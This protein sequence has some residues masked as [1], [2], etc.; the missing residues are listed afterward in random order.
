MKD[1]SG[2]LAGENYDNDPENLIN[3]ISPP[4]VLWTGNVNNDWYTIG[5]WQVSSGP[6]RYP[7]ITDNVVIEKK[8]NQPIITTDGAVA[9]TVEVQANAILTLQSAAPTD[10]TLKV[11]EDFYN[12]GTVIMSTGADTLAVGGNWRNTG[13]FVAGTGT[14]I[15]NSVS[16]IKSIDNLYDPFYN[17]YI[18]TVSDI[19]LLRNLTINKHFV[20]LNGNFDLASDARILTVKGDFINYDNFIA[21][22]AKVTFAGISGTQSIYP[23]SAVFY[24]IDID[25]GSAANVQITDNNLFINHNLNINSGNFVLNGKNLYIGDGNGIDALTVNGGLFYV[26]AN[27]TLRMANLSTIEVNAG[28]TM[29]LVGTDVDNPAYLQSQTGTY[30]F[31]VNSGATLGARYYNIQHVN[32]NGV[33][34]KNGS[35]LHTTNNFSDGV[36]R[37]GTSGGQYLWFENNFASDTTKI[38]GVYFHSG[39]TYNAKRLSGTGVVAFLD[40]LGLLAGYQFEEDIPDNSLDDGFVVWQYQNSMYVWTGAVSNDWNIAANW[41]VPVAVDPSGHAVPNSLGIASIPDVSFAS[42]RFPILGVAPTDDDGTCFDLLIEN[43]ASLTIANNKNLD[44]DNAITVYFGASLIISNGSASQINV[45]DTWSM[46]GTFS[47]GGNSTVVFDAPAGKLLTIAGNASFYNF[48]INSA[49]AAEYMSGGKLRIDNHFVV[50]QGIFTVSNATDT[51]F[52]AGDFIADGTFNHGNSVA[53]LNGTNQN[54]SLATSNSFYRL[55]C[56]GTNTKTLTSDIAIENDF[57]ILAGVTVGGSAYSISL[58]GDWINRGLFSPGTGTVEFIGNNTQIIDNYG[59]ENFYNFSVNNSSSTFP[60][61]VLYGDLVLG[62]NSWAMLDGIVETTADEMLYVGDLVALSGGNS[63]NS[64]VNGPMS[65]SGSANFV[66]PVGKDLKFARLGISG[67]SV[68]GTFLVE[69]FEAAYSDLS[70][71]A[72]GLDH[73]SGYEHW[74]IQRTAGLAEPVVSLY[75]TNG[76]ES[77]IDNLVTLTTAVYNTGE[78]QNTGNGVTSGTT[79]A[80]S[81]SSGAPIAIFGPITFGSLNE[82]NPLHGYTRWTG[83]FSQ[84]WNYLHNWTAG[85]PSAS[86]DAVIPAIPANQPII[87]NTAVV[88]KL[89]IDDGASL[90]IEPMQSLTLKGKLVVNGDLRLNSSDLG[91]AVL[92][93]EN[94]ITYG[95]NSRVITELFLEAGQFKYIASPTTQSQSD[96]IKSDPF[97]PYY[98][99]NL[100][101]YYEPGNTYNMLE[102]DWIELNG[103]LEPLTG[104]AFYGDKNITVEF[105]R[106]AVNENNFNTGDK[107]KTLYYTGSTEAEVLK[108][109]WNFVGNPYPANLDWDAVGWSKSNIYNSIYFWNGTNYSYYVSSGLAQDGGIGVNNATN[110]I[111]AEQ[112]FFLKVIEGGDPDQNQVGTLI[113]PASARTVNSHAFYKKTSNSYTD[114]FKIS[115][116]CSNGTDETA[117]RFL[118]GTSVGFDNDFDAFKIFPDKEMH[119][120]PQ[121]FSVNNKNV[122]IAINSL[123]LLNEDMVILLGFRAVE[124]GNFSLT[125]EPFE[126][127]A[128]YTAYLEDRFT[129]TTTELLDLKYDFFS[130]DGTFN[131]RFVIKFKK[132]PFDPSKYV[133]EMPDI[134]VYTDNSF[135]YLSSETPDAIVGQVRIYNMVGKLV[136]KFENNE[137]YL[138]KRAIN[139]EPGAYLVNIQS[140]YGRYSERIVIIK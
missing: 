86:L 21:R 92:L 90:N 96:I 118:D 107:S 62:G 47:H 33:R 74:T 12:A 133:S 31:N 84:V 77:G 51:L 132:E 19:Q 70:N 120:T 44:A 4:I 100:F 11:V 112:G 91:N 13:S 3:W 137:W 85:I 46:D 104:Y 102:E 140:V 80:G 114:I 43:G 18:N 1:Y 108:R 40:A 15:M 134:Y 97:S 10:T 52:V 17:L 26:D 59:T 63:A 79:A 2:A 101:S 48:T 121:L 39:A 57:F 115:V 28:G 122:P 128:N 35:S 60:Q 42:N 93:N 29:F 22:S 78:W 136:D 109:G 65:K 7:E 66:F 20:V 95:I 113:I 127:Q 5:N 81:I 37:N 23:G 32:A 111:P 6:D 103:I 68:V 56:L 76:E 34:F 125:V 88:R 131:N 130:E 38:S 64:Y 87:D 105:M 116:T 24:N 94:T 83:Q 8:T 129:Q 71:I 16:G 50:T 124:N 58:K 72:S 110:I 98:N 54:I 82:D 69:Y 61:I 30:S 119:K 53:Q 49:G 75:W 106:D 27:A 135:L 67:M 25:A 73:V 36:W 41:D 55:N 117:I 99:H 14:V 126:L 139:F 89:T 123:P 138:A 45:G 9:K